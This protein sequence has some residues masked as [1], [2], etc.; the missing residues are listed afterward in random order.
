MHETYDRDI[1]QLVEPTRVPAAIIALLK[2]TDHDAAWAIQPGKTAS[3]RAP[4]GPG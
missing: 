1:L 4:A 3:F 2:W